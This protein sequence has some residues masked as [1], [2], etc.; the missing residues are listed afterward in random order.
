MV[1]TPTKLGFFLNY[2]AFISLL[3]SF[4]PRKEND[5]LE[6]LQYDLNSPDKRT[7]KKKWTKSGLF[8]TFLQHKLSRLTK[9]QDSF[10]FPS[11]GMGGIVSLKDLQELGERQ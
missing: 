3:L 6:A 4:R 5:S 2:S 7:K 11:L 10:L 8:P 1:G 9:L